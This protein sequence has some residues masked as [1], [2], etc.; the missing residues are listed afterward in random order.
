MARIRTVKPSIWGD[1]RFAGLGRDARLLVIGLISSA[2]DEGRFIASA[3][4]IAG[5]VY[6]HDEIPPATIRRWRTEIAST[7]MIILYQVDGREY[8][9][10]PRWS[11]H[12]RINRP[13]PSAFPP[14]SPNGGCA[15]PS[16]EDIAPH[17]VSDSV[18]DSVSTAPPDHGV[19]GERLSGGR[20]GKGREGKGE[21]LKQVPISRQVT[22]TTSATPTT[23]PTSTPR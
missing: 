18:S 11:R 17:S 22:R 15:V 2:D 8:G 6:P 7:G 23:P 21:L 16:V 4:A 19:T 3:N 1:D 13:N 20:E 9:Y 10:F 12:Q 14:P 5:F